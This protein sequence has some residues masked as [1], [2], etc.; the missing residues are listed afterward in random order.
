MK[1]EL[2]KEIDTKALELLQQTR[3]ET[4]G[5]FHREIVSTIKWY[6]QDTERLEW[7]LNHPGAGIDVNRMRLGVPVRWHVKWYHQSKNYIAFGKT[8]RECI[9]NA[10]A[11]KV[12]VW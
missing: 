11:G 6:A 1:P 9:D 4:D 12:Q 3:M 2:E 8:M 5:K 7:L 10:L